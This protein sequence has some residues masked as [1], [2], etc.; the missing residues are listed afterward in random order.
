MKNEKGTTMP[1]LALLS[2]F[3]DR[4][5]QMS[6]HFITDLKQ[7]ELIKKGLLSE[8]ESNAKTVETKGL[9]PSRDKKAS[10]HKRKGLKP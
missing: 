1:V 8:N 9:Y 5:V 4:T 3:A 7:L 6:N 10:I 2:L